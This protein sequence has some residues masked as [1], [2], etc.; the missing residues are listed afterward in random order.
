MGDTA[1][2]T[3][4]WSKVSESDVFLS[5]KIFKI[6]LFDVGWAGVFNIIIFYILILLKKILPRRRREKILNQK[7]YNTAP[8]KGK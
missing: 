7:H 6:L 4:G 5:T 1:K 2:V 8:E 3:E